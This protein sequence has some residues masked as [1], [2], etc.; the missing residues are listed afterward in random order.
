MTQSLISIEDTVDAPAELLE[1]FERFTDDL[2][3]GV[4]ANKQISQIAIPFLEPASIESDSKEESQKDPDNNSVFEASHADPPNS[5]A[6]VR[7]EVIETE[8][9]RSAEYTN[10]KI[11]KFANEWSRAIHSSEYAH[12]I[13]TNLTKMEKL[14]IRRNRIWTTMT[15]EIYRLRHAIRYQIRKATKDLRLRT[16]QKFQ[17]DLMK[18]FISGEKFKNQPESSKAPTHSR[19]GHLLRGRLT[20]LSRGFQVDSFDDF[21][22]TGSSCLLSSQNNF[23]DRNS[24]VG[25]APKLPKLQPP[26]SPRPSSG[27]HASMTPSAA[28][29][30]TKSFLQMDLSR[31]TIPHKPI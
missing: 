20:E 28:K 23:D 25:S 13:R 4:I 6:S 16:I 14:E 29:K 18:L 19:A 7:T 26:S 9:L 1:D 2:V 12:D 21:Q 31:R 27:S 5:R 10:S 17:P 22:L 3:D 30:P 11:Q 15:E 8:Q 24:A